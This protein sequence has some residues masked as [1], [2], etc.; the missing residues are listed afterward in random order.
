MAISTAE[1]P[2]LNEPRGDL[3]GDRRGGDAF[4]DPELQEDLFKLLILR[5][6]ALFAADRAKALLHGVQVLARRPDVPPPAPVAVRVCPG[7]Q[8]QIRLLPP[9]A[10]VVPALE[11]GECPI[12]DL[13]LPRCILTPGTSDRRLP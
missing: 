5:S 2:L 11:P 10:Q 7:P 8:P 9:V 3:V 1:Q 4:E 12:R 6:E 13:V